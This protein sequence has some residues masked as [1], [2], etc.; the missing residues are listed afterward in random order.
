M[1]SNKRHD[2][3]FVLPDWYAF[4]DDARGRLFADYCTELG[5]LL[6]VGMGILDR[7][8]SILARLGAPEL[9]SVVIPG[10][11]I[12]AQVCNY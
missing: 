5:V 4:L 3:A 7:F 1:E 2:V 11:Q 10:Q 6:P 9:S 12:R 8:D